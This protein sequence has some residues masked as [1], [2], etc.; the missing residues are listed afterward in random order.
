VWIGPHV[1]VRLVEAFRVLQRLQMN[2]H[3]REFGSSWPTYEREFTDL[4]KYT[5]QEEWKAD[6][7][8]EIWYRWARSIPSAEEI[9]RMETAIVWPARYLASTPQ[10]L[11]TVG[12]AVVM[13]AR[14]RSLRAV[15]KR[16]DVPGRLCRRWYHEGLDQIAAGL[17]CD[18]V[19]VF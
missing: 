11:R 15:A 9:G 1:A 6:R 3:P 17:L 19:R 18:G 12:V 8:Q 7:R 16:L 14:H 2:G 10:L 5:D 4:A 13:K